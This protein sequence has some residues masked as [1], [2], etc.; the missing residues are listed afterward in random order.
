MESKYFI[1]KKFGREYQFDY[2]NIEFIDVENSKKK[3][4]IIFYSKTAKMRYM[5]GDKDGVVLDTL[6]KKCPNVMSVEEFRRKH[7]E[8]K[9]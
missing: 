4:M 2:S 8:E 1:Q 5:L 9:L 7:P 6:I 3:K